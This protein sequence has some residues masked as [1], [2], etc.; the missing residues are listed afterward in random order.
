[1]SDQ[2][3]LIGVDQARYLTSRASSR[4]EEGCDH[5]MQVRRMVH[6]VALIE[7]RRIRGV[8]VRVSRRGDDEPG[9]GPISDQTC[10]G[11]DSNV[12]SLRENEQWEGR[13]SPIGAESSGDIGR[14]V[15][16]ADRE[17]STGAA[18]DRFYYVQNARPHART[19]FRCGRRGGR[20]MRGIRGRLRG[21]SPKGRSRGRRARSRLFALSIGGTGRGR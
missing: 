8:G 4:V 1:M 13:S 17:D 7:C 20:G 14:R 6:D 9:G 5:K 2:A 15:P 16:D 10:V 21:R 11:G 3:D 18:G 12:I 19:A